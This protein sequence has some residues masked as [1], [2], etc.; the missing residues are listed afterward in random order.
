M[1]EQNYPVLKEKVVGSVIEF[2]PDIREQFDEI[3]HKKFSGFTAYQNF[4]KEN[5]ELILGLCL[6]NTVNLR[7]IIFFFQYF[8]TVFSEVSLNLINSPLNLTDVL[9]E[10]LRF[11]LAISIEYKKGALSFTK[12]QDLDVSLGSIL[13]NIDWSK[14]RMI[15]GGVQNEEIKS[16]KE[17]FQSS[18]YPAKEFRYYDSIYNFITGGD[19]FDFKKLLSELEHY[20]HIEKGVLLPQYVLFQKLSYPTCFSLNDVDY[21]GD[22]RKLMEY[23]DQGAFDLPN[24][25]SIFHFATRFGNPL[26]YNLLKLQNRIIKGLH[27]G[28][29]Q[30]KYQQS[31]GHFLSI[32]A[33][34]EHS[35]QLREIRKACLEINDAIKQK[36]YLR[37]SNRLEALC[38]SDFKEFQSLFNE[39]KGDLRYVPYLENFNPHKFYLFFLRA[40]NELRW[41]VASFFHH[42]Y[43]EYF[44]STLSPE[45]DFVRELFAKI[46]RK[47][48]SLK[49]GLG[50]FF[51]NELHNDLLNA[52]VKLERP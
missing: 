23:C 43:N 8:Q 2:V 48:N 1:S 36:Q 14:M 37:E 10:L 13:D 3:I 12:R 4:L 21:L 41:E 20:F 46:E 31:L 33:S 35:S 22:T 30:Y 24:Y 49:A 50:K 28:K 7:T 6:G 34:S 18:Y 25:M 29:H 27:R 19:S 15:D 26:N 44:S 52:V 32:S 9:I 45:I 17:I 39:S 42:R 47:K 51:F 16:F 40:S 38:Y 5:K 11:S